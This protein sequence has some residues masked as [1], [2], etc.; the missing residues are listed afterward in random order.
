MCYSVQTWEYIY[1]KYGEVS[2]AFSRIARHLLLL[3]LMSCL[4]GLQYAGV[5]ISLQNSAKVSKE[6]H[7]V[8]RDI[9]M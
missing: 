3:K 1:Y 6:L 7:C 9:I 4:N 8:S 5:W 2:S